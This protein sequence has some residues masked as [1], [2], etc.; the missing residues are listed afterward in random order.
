MAGPLSVA[1]GEEKPC[2]PATRSS[3]R[4]SVARQGVAV[5]DGLAEEMI[6]R[7][8]KPK[9][10]VCEPEDASLNPALISYRIST[11]PLFDT[12]VRDVERRNLPLNPSTLGRKSY[13]LLSPALPLIHFRILL[14]AYLPYPHTLFLRFFTSPPPSP[15]SSTLQ[16]ATLH[17]ILLS[18]LS[19]PR[20]RHLRGFEGGGMEGAS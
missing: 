10:P 16:T 7:A 6:Y 1:A 20:S 18:F 5:R 3:L 9:E 14:L 2:W 19:S 17:S 11:M 8:R 12:R 15:L 13:F 4:P